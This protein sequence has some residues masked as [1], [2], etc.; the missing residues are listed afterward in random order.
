V[1]EDQPYYKTILINKKQFYITE[2]GFLY[3]KS[4]NYLQESHSWAID[5]V[6]QMLDAVRA[7]LLINRGVR[8][9]VIIRTIL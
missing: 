8:W 1:L 5:F 3:V 9:A 6:Q 2:T 7:E 4:M